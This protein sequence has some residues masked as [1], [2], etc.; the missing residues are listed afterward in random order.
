MEWQPIKT[1]PKD[2][3]LFLAYYKSH[4]GAGGYIKESWWGPQNTT[5]QGWLLRGLMIDPINTITHWMPLP[6]C[7]TTDK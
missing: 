4:G 1:A 3:T 7:P 6:P 2:G 5:K